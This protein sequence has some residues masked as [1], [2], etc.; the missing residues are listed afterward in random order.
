MKT[1]RNIIVGITLIASLCGASISQA[2]NND[3]AGQAGA[4]QLLINPWAQSSGWGG[5]NSGSVR[6]VESM[7]LNIAG[8]AFTQKTQIAFSNTAWM[9]GSGITINAFGLTQKISDAGVLGLG[10][11]SMGFGEIPVTTTELPEGGLGNFTPRF[12]NVSL[13]YA[14]AFSNSI[15]GGINTKM[16]SESISDVGTEGIAFDAGIHYVTGIGKG[17][18]GK[19]NTDNLK[20]G[21]T[22]KN[23]GPQMRYRG[24]G[25]SL[26]GIAAS[27]GSTLT[28]EQ[29]SER[30]EMPSLVN[31]GGAY[32][33][34]ISDMHRVTFAGNFTSNSFTENQYIGGVEYGFRSYFMLRTGYVWEAGKH[35]GASVNAFTGLCAGL[36]ANLPLGKSGKTFGIDYSFRETQPFQNTHSVGVRMDL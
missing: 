17:S 19:K 22:L 24:D 35:T 20:F 1:N 33:Y 2:G 29:R 25:L 23:V 7:F 10:V 30:F 15:Y 27:T 16:I 12:I 3:R 31:I 32:D 8:I 11:T 18:D 36:S 4:G 21:I 5:A 34:K 13:S 26:R 28:F 14:K 9:K 6:G